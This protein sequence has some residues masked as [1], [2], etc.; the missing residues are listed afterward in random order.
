MAKKSVKKE[1]DEEKNTSK[2]TTPDKKSTEKKTTPK[3][4]SAK[5]KTNTKQTT[6]NEAEKKGKLTVSQRE[7]DEIDAV[8]DT[9]WS[10]VGALTKAWKTS[11]SILIAGI[12][13]GLLGVTLSGWGQE[14]IGLK[15]SGVW[16][17]I[18]ENP[19]D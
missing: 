17:A 6:L 10:F 19:N 2:K 12:I 14:V 5:K 11:R 15:Q 4:T 1:S 3:K 13:I 7:R 8:V 16:Y 18:T 9:L